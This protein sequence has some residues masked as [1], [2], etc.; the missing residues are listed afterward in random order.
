MQ[1]RACARLQ[2][3]CAIAGEASLSQ[4]A[5]R[6]MWLP[7]SPIQIRNRARESLPCACSVLGGAVQDS[8]LLK[9]ALGRQQR[10]GG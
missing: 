9:E 2:L 10:P 6:H 8:H 1:A 7:V 5:V 3:H 4:A